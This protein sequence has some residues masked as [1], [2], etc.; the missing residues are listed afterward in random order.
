MI[1]TRAVIEPETEPDGQA[2]L[3]PVCLTDDSID[4]YPNPDD[5]DEIDSETEFDSET[6]NIVTGWSIWA[7]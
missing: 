5:D 1:Q 6:L 7:T 3:E 2:H 4:E